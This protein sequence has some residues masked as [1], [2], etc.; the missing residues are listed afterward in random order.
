MILLGSLLVLFR[1]LA[2]E[3]VW[4]HTWDIPAGLPLPAVRQC[5]D[6]R[7]STVRARQ[8]DKYGGGVQLGRCYCHPSCV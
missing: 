7:F 8:I 6:S 1:L 3:L 5:A 2:P 4:L